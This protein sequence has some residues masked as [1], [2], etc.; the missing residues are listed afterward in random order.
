MDIYN[1]LSAKY[2]K[3]HG[4]SSDKWTTKD[5][6]TQY[7]G[8]VN[9][10][11]NAPFIPFYALYIQLCIFLTERDRAVTLVDTSVAAKKQHR[12]LVTL[13]KTIELDRKELDNA[14]AGDRQ[15]LRNTLAEH[16]DMQLAYQN[17]PPKVIFNKIIILKKN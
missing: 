12:N 16:R 2:V 11:S 15:G 4:M 10:F 8:L 5:K 7:K 3:V 9:L 17:T 6:I 14:I 1:S 13:R